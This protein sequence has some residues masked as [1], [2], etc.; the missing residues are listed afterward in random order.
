MVNSEFEWDVV[1]E[2]LN[3][4]KHG[5]SFS[6]ASETF[7]DPKG[8]QIEDLRHSR[9]EKRLYWIGEAPSGRILTTWFTKRENVIRIIGSA[10]LRKFRKFYY[11][12]TQTE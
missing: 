12:N 9:F 1:K 4:E 2:I 11:E 7:S 3:L 6:E 5:I 8:L 10:E